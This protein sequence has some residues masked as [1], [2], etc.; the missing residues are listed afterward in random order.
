MRLN[1]FGP[2]PSA[3]LPTDATP[4][5]RIAAR[6]RTAQDRETGAGRRAAKRASDAARA[7]L[8]G[9][10]DENE[11]QLESALATVARFDVGLQGLLLAELDADD[12]ITQHS[13]LGRA[14]TPDGG[15]PGWLRERALRD[16]AE[17]VV[18]DWLA[19]GAVFS[20]HREFSARP[21]D[22]P[23]P[24]LY[25]ALS[26]FR[27]ESIAVEGVETVGHEACT[28]ILHVALALRSAQRASAN[29]A[30][31]GA[32]GYAAADSRR[33]FDRT[34][35]FVTAE[36]AEWIVE[37]EP[38]DGQIA[39]AVTSGRFSDDALTPE[40]RSVGISPHDIDERDVVAALR[41][42]RDRG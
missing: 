26:L 41:R 5:D 3:T 40:G 28:R 39:A 16:D 21:A 13:A 27:A 32:T 6:A 22:D 30:L 8:T 29:R 2:K 12:P 31:G 14:T 10:L 33:A 25:E 4:A 1:P 42:A 24:Q 36:L 35:R 19:F 15:L 9:Q 17:R 38:G 23:L 7:V 37:R 20:A 34:H 11:A 18:R